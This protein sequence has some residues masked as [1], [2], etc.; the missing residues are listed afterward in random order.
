MLLACDGFF[1]AIQPFEV[2]DHVLEHLMQSK[3]DGLH[4]AERL[5]AAA[6]EGGSTDNITVLVV[7][8]REPKNILSDCLRDAKSCPD[9][10]GGGSAADSLFDFFSAKA[11]K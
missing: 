1:D 8:L 6:K 10:G 2:V 5:V 3:G 11:G 4:T 9:G 7:F